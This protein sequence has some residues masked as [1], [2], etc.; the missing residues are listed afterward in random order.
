[1]L[2]KENRK[3]ID[4]I[5]DLKILLKCY[6]KVQF[7]QM[8]RKP[9]KLL[10]EKISKGDQNLL[11]SRKKSQITNGFEKIFEHEAGGSVL[12]PFSGK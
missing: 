2:S 4:S 7:L 5:F 9:P 10:N 1:M 12:E 11:A 8:M 3:F 6:Q